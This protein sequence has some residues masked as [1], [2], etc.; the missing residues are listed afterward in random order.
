MD[1]AYGERKK[2]LSEKEKERGREYEIFLSWSNHVNFL[3][4]GQTMKQYS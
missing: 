4:I 1:V 2:G 3:I